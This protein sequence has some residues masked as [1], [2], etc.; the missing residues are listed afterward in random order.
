MLT[1]LGSRSINKPL[2]VG[3]TEAAQGNFQRLA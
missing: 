1:K 3:S 2:R